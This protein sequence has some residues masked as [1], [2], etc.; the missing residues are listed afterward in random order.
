MSK[1][2]PSKQVFVARRWERTGRHHYLVGKFADGKGRMLASV[3]FYG[4]QHG[5]WYACA[6]GPCGYKRTRKAAMR[7]VLGEVRK[8][9][10]IDRRVT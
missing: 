4:R 1:R 3:L 5:W 10:T 2:S 8:V 9:T 7:F 6:H